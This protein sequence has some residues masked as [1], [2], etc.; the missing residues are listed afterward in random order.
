MGEVYLAYDR[1]LEREIAIKVLREGSGDAR[2]FEQEAKAASALQHPNVAHVYEIGSHDGFRYI[3][4]ELVRGETLRERIARG[5]MSID[6]IVEVSLQISSA[7]AAAHKAGI[8][9]R[10]IKPENVIVTEDQYAKVLDFGLAKLRGS[11]GH[12]AATVLKT[13]SG[14][15]M[16][17]RPYMAPE[18]FL[19]SDV[20]AAADV[21]SLGV[22]M[23]EMVAGQRPPTKPLHQLRKDTPPLLEHLVTKS[24]AKNPADR[25]QDGGEVLQQLQAISREGRMPVPAMKSGR[26][27]Q[28]AVALVVIALVAVAAF[29][30]LR[31][32]RKREALRNIETAEILLKERKLDE[33]Y[34]L[35]N[36]A[37]AVVPED[38]RLRDIIANVSDRLTIASDP[39][40]AT[41]FLQKFKGAPQRE[42]VGV[43]PITTR[44]V[45]GDYLLT[46]EK[47]G[48]ASVVRPV[49]TM[50]LYLGTD[51]FAGRAADIRVKL[52]EQ[53]KVPAGMVKVDGEAYRLSGFY[54][55]S[56]RVVELRDYFIDRY[57]VT[58]GDYE[59]FVRDGGYRRRELWKHPF[60]DGGKRLSFEQAMARFRDKTGLPGPRGWS[61]GA[62]ADGA[63]NHPVTDV[64]WYEAAA[65]AT[66]QGKQLP[67]VH[68]W[69]RAA[70]PASRESIAAAFPWGPVGSGVDPT[71]RAN[72]AG[73][74]TMEVS[75]MP[76]GVSPWGAHHMAGNVSE[77]CR[78]VHG[79]G[80][81]ARGGGWNDAVYA[82][83]QTA[84]LPGFFSS[85][86][87]GFRCVIGGGGDEGDFALA[88]SGFVPTY[89]A[90]DD[91]TFET[92]RKRFD[93]Q[94]EE[95]NARV[96]E[97]VETT[98]WTREKIALTASGKTFHAYLYLPK[99]FRRPLQVIHFA[100]AGDVVGGWK[101]LPHSIE[102]QW[103]PVIRAGRAVFAVELEGFLGRPRPPG[104]VRPETDSDEYVE[105]N[106]GRVNDM[107]RGLDYLESRPDIDRS[108]IALLG[109]SAGGGT[110]VFIS[111]LE[112]RYRS[113]LFG[114]TGISIREVRIAPA[115]NRINFVPR[116]KAP[117]L[118]LQGRYDEDTSLK[119]ETEPMFRLLK[120]PKRLQIYDGGHVAPREI[121]IPAVTN[122]L[123]ETMGPVEQ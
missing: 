100:P 20:T 93:Y 76:F 119:S 23:H 16:G 106:V 96:V 8:V 71:E 53:A 110:G 18:Q 83:G 59:K 107:R 36:A 85:P 74:G 73:K 94:R 104:W 54:R 37:A 51:M 35:A 113:V 25:Y 12:D 40:G 10:D 24:L 115:A 87:L 66:W 67:T 97:R 103:A 41:V 92:F 34:A 122:W 112:S 95:M 30:M 7:L 43:T 44:R 111:A 33:A 49:T 19:D 56:D 88:E 75:T 11:R 63:E 6:Q 79:D 121:A 70:R 105:Y 117:K 86:T 28:I 120:E 64:T 108:R 15:A 32:N 114:G 14:V 69:E 1:D 98:S 46:F 89:T 26:G 31:S 52:T 123:D 38:D 22:V 3:A 68:Q 58:N 84:A 116:I 4:M 80:F 78:N 60:V 13:E 90:V 39:P 45:R 102:V 5:A 50:P 109:I 118:L 65:F 61:D 2:R 47:A 48:Y 9:H 99:G 82:F 81:A 42:R 62:P 55:P 29:V 72:F 21:Y 101:T 27:R 17:T 91:A 77:W 57:E